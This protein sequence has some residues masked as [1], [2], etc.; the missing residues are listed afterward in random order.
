MPV[1]FASLSLMK[2]P[3]IYTF[4]IICLF[5]VTQIFAQS[6]MKAGV[7]YGRV[8]N[9][10]SKPLNGVKV[11]LESPIIAP[12]FTNSTTN[13]NFRFANLL[14]GSYSVSFFSPGYLPTLRKDVT[15][16]IGEQVE[17]NVILERTLEKPSVLF[18][19]VTDKTG[20]PLEGVVVS[21]E[22][23]IFSS[24]RRGTFRVGNC[25]TSR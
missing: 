18:G 21:V 16:S 24:S 17:L 12:I 10:E 13:G 3:L 20:H 15:V 7:I 14:P 4:P 23:D 19:I 9:E 22:S 2:V 6:A 8:V 5:A 11:R 25:P 1:R